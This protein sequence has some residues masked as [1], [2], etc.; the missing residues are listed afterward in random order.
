MKIVVRT[1]GQLRAILAH[2]EEM[3]PTPQY[4]VKTPES[5]DRHA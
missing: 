5:K 1:A 3:H 4:T 2:L